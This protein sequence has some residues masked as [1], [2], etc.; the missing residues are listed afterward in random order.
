MICLKK[1]M[2]LELLNYIK[3]KD[4]QHE[5]VCDIFSADFTSKNVALDIAIVVS[6]IYFQQMPRAKLK[7]IN[8][9]L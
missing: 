1:V 8:F 4:M 6:A 9:H 2:H 5:C 3:C 7:C